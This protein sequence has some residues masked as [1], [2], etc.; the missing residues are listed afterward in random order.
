MLYESSDRFFPH[1]YIN[2][3]DTPI[4]YEQSLPASE[5][6][7]IAEKEALEFAIKIFAVFGWFPAE[8]AL[9]NL[10]EDQKKLIER[11]L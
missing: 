7:A 4:T 5:L 6:T 3:G 8:P 9:R 2:K 10:A 11:R 1:Q